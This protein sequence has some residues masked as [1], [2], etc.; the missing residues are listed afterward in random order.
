M[1]STAGYQKVEHSK[2]QLVKWSEMMLLQ[3]YDGV[4][5]S[6]CWAFD[7]HGD[8]S[9]IKSFVHE[10]LHQGA[11]DHTINQASA[12]PCRSKQPP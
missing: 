7:E 9:C 4:G 12:P 1:C 5:D 2:P 3:I 11:K 6:T 8:D 10:L